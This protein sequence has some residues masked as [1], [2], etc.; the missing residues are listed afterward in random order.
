[1]SGA[2]EWVGSLGAWGPLIFVSLYIL[3]CVLFL[4]GSVLTLGA[5][6]L[7]GVIKGSIIVSISST[8]GATCAF[9]VGRYLARDWVANKI[10]ANEKFKA[11][12]DAVAR[13]GW[14]IVGLT[15]LSPVFP[16]N[17]LN[18][19]YGLTRVSL[20]D[21]FFASWIGMIPGTVM[22]VYIG[23]LAG[24]VAKLGTE[25][26]TR[27]SAEWALYIV[28]L[29]ATVVVTVFITRIAREALKKKV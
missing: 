20:R 28:G 11:I 2:L 22:Y 18:Y 7:F 4:P 15:R 26:R 6:G 27:T 29:I 14:K 24:E 17:L 1:L 12:D 16:F 23:S 19:A 8:L 25:G 21:Y 13:E 5:G 3:A 9:L 10:S